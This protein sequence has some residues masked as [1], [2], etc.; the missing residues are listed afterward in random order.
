MN[1]QHAWWRHGA[2]TEELIIGSADSVVAPRRL[3]RSVARSAPY[4]LP[5]FVYGWPTL[6]FPD[7]GRYESVAPLFRITVEPARTPTGQWVLNAVT[8]PEFNTA[9]A[10]VERFDRAT[11][12]HLVDELDEGL[13]FGDPP[14][15]VALAKD[16][17]NRLGV[18]VRTA[19]NPGEL[20]GYLPRRDGLYNCAVTIKAKGQYLGGVIREL[21][22][23]RDR[24][25]WT[26]TAAAFLVTGVSE[27]RNRRGRS[28]GRGVVSPM[29]SN[30]SQEQALER[31][32]MDPITVITGPPGTGKTQLV[33]NAVSD[34]WMRDETILV[35]SVNNAAVNVPTER[36]RDE[37]CPGLLI[38][39]G[40]R[41]ARE[42]VAQQV[43]EGTAWA[44]EQRDHSTR[45]AEAA[46][47]T[48]AE[49]RRQF[50]DDLAELAQIDARLLS[51]AVDA[52]EKGLQ[53]ETASRAIWGDHEPEDVPPVSRKDERRIPKLRRARHFLARSAARKMRAKYR[54]RPDT[55]LQDL[56]LYAQAVDGTKKAADELDSNERRREA[57]S[58]RVGNIAERLPEHDRMWQEAAKR[59]V[60]VKVAQ[61]VRRADVVLDQTFGYA[62]S[63][64]KSFRKAVA[65]GLRHFKGWGCTALAASSNFPL[66]EGIFDLVVVDEASQCTV[67][68]VLP[69][70]YRA[71][72]V[73]VV[74]DPRQLQPV[75]TIS[76]RRLKA[77]AADVK[78]NPEDLEERGLDHAASVYEAFDSLSP[79]P[80]AVFLDEHYRSHPRIAA[81]FNREFYGERLSV[82]TDLA[83]KHT[84]GG[85]RWFDVDGTAA[86]GNGSWSNETEA[87]VAVSQLRKVLATGSPRTVGFLSP[88]RG[89]AELVDRLLRQQIQEEILNAAD[90]RAGTAHALQ[91][92]E[93]DVIVFSTVVAPGM[94]S[95]ARA[96]V[97]KERHLV[98]VAVSRARQ[99]VV[100][101]GHPDV[102]Q[103][104]NP[105]IASL[106]SEYRH[107]LEDSSLQPHRASSVQ[108]D[109]GAE[110]LLYDAAMRAGIPLTS[111][112]DVGGYELDFAIE[113]PKVK[114]NIEVDG[115]V[116]IDA[117]GRQ[118]RQDVARD[119][120]LMDRGWVVHR[121]PAWRCHR[122]P[123][124]EVRLIAHRLS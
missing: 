27:I 82:L 91:G 51:L 42:S 74:G 117:R 105:T 16:L 75:V 85:I 10:T 119:R 90:F 123:D 114:L 78:Y 9:L 15:F 71:K 102:A 56:L 79:G 35:T 11:V 89:Q 43:H 100:V 83:G 50:H 120:R 110:R 39:T 52:E 22:L 53:A 76:P 41:E 101:I 68:S 37:V 1:E 104:D 95:Y 5:Q 33:V 23:L 88:F 96:W 64:A 87:Q 84:N 14:S 70:L 57:L 97:E 6:V 124:A 7:T 66:R 116:H 38:R 26:Q 86:R 24:T 55:P 61:D 59:L 111:K 58:A 103:L 62:P 3:A 60:A 109:S 30:Y 92:N 107:E 112:A 73:A 115:P 122:D 94:T 20:N 49:R 99:T 47:K 93:R 48:E 31:L 63:R 36:A 45:V 25:D 98:N 28:G 18:D 40:N 69:L 17:A 32:S 121:I 113:T 77:I 13:P 12:E 4:E 21:R 81:W 34:A 118:R 67:A 65:R 54:L 106:R 80:Q 2:A 108:I 8:E 29:T 44:T 19:P 72:R 46:H